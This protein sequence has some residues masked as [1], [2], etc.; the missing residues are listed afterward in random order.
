VQLGPLQDN[1]YPVQAGLSEG[2]PVITANLLSL[3]HGLPVQVR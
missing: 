3:R 1:R 2:Q